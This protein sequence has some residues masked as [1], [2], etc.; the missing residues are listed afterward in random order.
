LRVFSVFSP[1]SAGN[2]F[3]EYMASTSKPP[4]PNATAS[5]KADE[6]AI[7]LIKSCYRVGRRFHRPDG[8]L[9]DLFREIQKSG[10]AVSRTNLTKIIKDIAPPPAPGPRPFKRPRPPQAIKTQP[11][12]KDAANGSA[13]SSTAEPE[14][15]EGTRF[16]LVRNVSRRTG[17][18]SWG[19]LDSWLNTSALC[20]VGVTKLDTILEMNRLNAPPAKVRYTKHGMVGHIVVDEEIAVEDDG[21]PAV[22]QVDEDEDE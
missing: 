5:I 16:S 22:S 2:F 18:C 12:P 9:I 17:E 21:L 1:L 19:I 3:E 15:A 10:Y 4:R 14:E 11:T 20:Y 8:Q 6:R 13:D 7:S